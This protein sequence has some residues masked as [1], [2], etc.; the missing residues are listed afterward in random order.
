MNKFKLWLNR[1][2]FKIII[3]TII[4]IMTYILLKSMGSYNKKDEEIEKQ[5]NTY[6]YENNVVSNNTSNNFILSDKSKEDSQD[7]ISIA[8]KIITTIYQANLNNDNI[9]LKQEIYN[10][11]PDEVIEDLL[12]SGENINVNSIL[13][14]TFYVDDIKNYKIGKVYKGKEENNIVQ[15]AVVLR[16]QKDENNPIDKYLVINMDYNNSTFSYGGI[17][18]NLDDFDS[19]GELCEIK[20]KGS[21]SF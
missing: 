5:E 13:N 11:F 2:D 19:S 10:M 9:S 8:E 17:V 1:N 12:N 4:I 7:I 20:N 6:S 21:N 14:F 3:I 18:N 15:Y 16:Y